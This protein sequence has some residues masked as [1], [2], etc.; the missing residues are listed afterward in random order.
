[1]SPNA[2]WHR[3]SIENIFP[4]VVTVAN[5]GKI[6]SIEKRCRLSIGAR[7]NVLK[8]GDGQTSIIG[9][10]NGR[11]HGEVRDNAANHNMPDAPGQEP[12]EQSCVVEGVHAPFGHDQVGGVGAIA[13]GNSVPQVPSTAAPCSLSFATRGATLN[14]SA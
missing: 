6:F 2:E 9:G 1:M 5:I 12:V 11:F 7:T 3:F 10:P 8:H 4:I 14:A 13:S